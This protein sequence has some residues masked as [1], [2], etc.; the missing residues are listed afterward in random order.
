MLHDPV[1][2]T[3]PLFLGTHCWEWLGEVLCPKES[4]G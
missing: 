1:H 2:R 3:I 4:M